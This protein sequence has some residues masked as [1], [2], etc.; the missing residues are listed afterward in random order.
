[1]GTQERVAAPKISIL[2]ATWNCSSLLATFFRSLEE[3]STGDWEL[4]ILDNCSFDGL[5]QLVRQY[6][7]A[8]PD[9]LIRFSSQTDAGIYDAWNRGIK[10]AEG[11]Y[12]CFIGADDIFVSPES[13]QQLLD[14]TR[15]SAELITCRNAYYSSDGHFL[16]DWGSAWNWRRMRE[17][18]N[19]AHP[20]ML[21]RRV[22]F[23]RFGLFDSSFKICGDYEWFLRLTPE[24]RS[25]H[26]PT[27]VLK[28]VQAG[29]SHT[30]IG[31]VYAET[32]RAQ[33][34]HLNFFWSAVCWILNWLKY[35]R[36]RLIG[37]T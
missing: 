37:L 7:A 35:S 36:R 3:Q 29:V 2:M 31:A 30:R 33:T 26:A 16:R 34:R 32:F 9:Q 10:L 21:V 27:S 4:L 12:L 25:I 1:M 23:E 24:V 28:I 20:G 15:S 13:L 11:D 19:I 8:H 22:L 6:Q 17:S 18:M 5:P 14:L